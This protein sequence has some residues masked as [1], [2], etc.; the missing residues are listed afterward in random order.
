MPNRRVKGVLNGAIAAA[1]YGTNPL[2]ALPLFAGGIGVNSVLFYRYAI[3]VMIYGL[4]LKFVKKT[5]LHLTK[6]EFVPLFIL[7]IFFS[8]PI[9]EIKREE[10]SFGCGLSKRTNSISPSFPSSASNSSGN[11]TFPS[12]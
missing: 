6:K 8:F 9:T 7:A 3:A 4:W 2:F 5:S 1:S 12:L 11:P 10:K